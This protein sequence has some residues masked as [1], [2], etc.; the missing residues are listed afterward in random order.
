VAQILFIIIF[1]HSLE[2]V[3][4]HYRNTHLKGSN[5]SVWDFLESIG[6]NPDI[7]TEKLNLGVADKSFYKTL[8]NR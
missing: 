6:L 7:L 8:G 4:D 2:S 5:N 1:M 3:F